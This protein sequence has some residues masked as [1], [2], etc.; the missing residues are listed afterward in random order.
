MKEIVI[1]S[2]QNIE[3]STKLE[4][5]IAY[6]EIFKN[7]DI[8]Q[9]H[10]DNIIDND[11]YLFEDK[12]QFEKSSIISITIKKLLAYLIPIIDDYPSKTIKKTG[13]IIKSNY[14]INSFILKNN[15][16]IPFRIPNNTN[17]ILLGFVFPQVSKISFINNLFINNLPYSLNK[18]KEL[19]TVEDYSNFYSN[20]SINNKLLKEE[21]YSDLTYFIIKNNE[22]LLYDELLEIIKYYH[23]LYQ[24]N[25]LLSIIYKDKTNENIFD[26]TKYLNSITKHNETKYLDIF[27][28][29]LPI[30]INNYYSES[31]YATLKNLAFLDIYNYIKLYGEDNNFVSIKL[32]EIQHKFKL[33]QEVHLNE[34]NI[35]QNNLKLNK[36]ELICKKLF[37]NL[38][39][40][41]HKDNLFNKKV[42]FN[43]NLLSKK[44]KDIIFIEYGKYENFLNSYYT[45]KCEHIQLLQQFNINSDINTFNNL[46]PYINLSKKDQ[47]FTCK[48]CN[49]NILCPH[50]YELYTQLFSIK[51]TNTDEDQEYIIR[52]RII[53]KYMANTPINFIYYCKYC[54][55]E[56][57][58]S[59][60]MEQYVKYN[61]SNN[62]ILTDEI[63][64]KIYVII[65]YILTNYVQ[66]NNLIIKKKQLINIILDQIIDPVN[67]ISMNLYKAK[68]N[69][70]E[71]IDNTLSINITI[72]IFAALL[73]L[74]TKYKEI[75]IIN[76]KIKTGGLIKTKQNSDQLK[77][78][79]K[80]AFDDIIQYQLFNINAI[81]LQH[82]SIQNLLLEY[83]RNLAGNNINIQIDN[84]I[85]QINI[86]D[87]IKSNPIYNYV[88]YINKIYNKKIK[89]D[90]ISYLLNKQENDFLTIYNTKKIDKEL[91]NNLYSN[92]FDKIRLPFDIPK[93]IKSEEDYIKLSYYQF[94]Y[95]V[96]NGLYFYSPFPA[97]YSKDILDKI[98]T[99]QTITN[100]IVSYDK[101]KIDQ[102]R[103]F[104]MVA[105]FYF[106][107]N[108]DRIFR[109]NINNLNLYYCL[110][111]IRHKFNTYIYKDSKNKI[112][113]FQKKQLDSIVYNKDLTFVDRQCNNCMI[114]LK[115]ILK[116]SKTTIQD[117]NTTI[118]NNIQLN[119]EIILFFNKYR[120]HCPIGINQIHIFVKDKCKNCG[121]SKEELDNND[122]KY[123]NKYKKNYDDY[124]KNKK[125]N[126]LIKYKEQPI[127]SI[128]DIL[129]NI[130]I[131]D[132]KED[133]FK[134][135]INL[136]KI[137]SDKFKL[138]QYQ[139]QHLGIFEG[140]NLDEV[141]EL[142]KKDK[143]ESIISQNTNN[144]QI[145]LNNYIQ[146]LYIY[147]NLLRKSYSIGKLNEVDLYLIIQ[148]IK[149]D[150]SPNIINKLPLLQF[151]I[152]QYKTYYS[153]KYS[154]EILNEHLLN[155]IL[156]NIL[157]L[158]N[159]T[160]NTN[161]ETIMN[162]FLE[163]YLK[164]ITYQ[165]E[166]FSKFEYKL[167]KFVTP[168]GKVDEDMDENYINEAD[169]E[170]E[171]DEEDNLFS[172][173]NFDLNIDA[174]E[175]DNGD[176]I[177]HFD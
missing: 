77:N 159:S 15:K 176:G 16:L 5:E 117:N 90:D 3:P 50:K 103:L 33:L 153:Y 102:N 146:S 40:I 7:I 20:I 95:Y 55:E 9:Y 13:I 8:S 111:G 116:Q 36:Y 18:Y 26:L 11:Q 31:T 113:T 131:K 75:S 51:D 91:I 141:V 19:I 161:M 43:I 172:Y 61:K 21:H 151:D 115:D 44:Y 6:N 67:T 145:K 157:F 38:F 60:D 170:E 107:S 168:K 134:N 96:V 71:V 89:F 86:I 53:H 127:I 48:K 155:I 76:P 173:D 65:S 123:Y 118:N 69:S 46:K 100:Q 140:L 163:F 82:K 92:I 52:N 126:L 158:I 49:F 58:K 93:D 73:C 177:D 147:Y 133:I 125:N 135:N 42:P 143:L 66:I 22:E 174:D 165:D 120:I 30:K 119:D 106:P 164:K 64:K 10:I 130:K 2:K 101:F 94:Y 63:Q 24:N 110:S 39:N 98:N 83:Y 35:I 23:D 132:N 114:Y 108:S 138:K 175:L 160:I 34:I 68:T 41:L 28:K 152:N 27:N 57:G 150:V 136:S 74:S 167:L 62:N 104:Y 105:Y 166:L 128:D 32:K 14:N 121:V 59:L 81:K 162:E 97:N 1:T 54:S 85:K 169:I 72:Y 149:K 84:S 17:F 139:L 124:I 148:K 37:P 129:K 12:L 99:Y 87:S 29:Y 142:Y 137:I 156:K 154:D 171:I 45:N 88:Y 109:Y 80:N 79:F 25:N 112:H 4:K 122:I 47:I 144:R 70:E 78:N 56:I